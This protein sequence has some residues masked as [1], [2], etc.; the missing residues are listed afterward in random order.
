[1]NA[2]AKSITPC[3]VGLVYVANVVPSL[4]IKASLPF[5]QHR[6]TYFQ[7]L[8][9]ATILMFTS[10][11]VVIIGQLTNSPGLCLFG[12]A[13][14]AAQ[15]GLGEASLLA[16]ASLYGDRSRTA[17][18]AW[19]SGTGFA[20]IF[21]YA[22]V[23]LF[24]R[25]FGAS[26]AVTLFFGLCVPVSYAYVYFWCL[27][28]PS[29]TSSSA[30]S[31]NNRTGEGFQNLVES[32]ELKEIEIELELEMEMTTTTMTTT[33]TTTTTAKQD[34]DKHT[35]PL[36]TLPHSSKET[37][38]AIFNLWPY[39]I[40]LFTVYFAEYAMQSGTWSAMGFPVTDSNARKEFYMNSNFA[41]QIGV[42]ISRSSGNIMQC[43][44]R[45]LWIMPTLQ[46]MFLI[47]FW[48]DAAYMYWYDWSLM[49]PCFV[50]GLLGGATYVGAF[51]LINEEIPKGALR[52]F[53]L[54]A[55]SVADSLGIVMSDLF[56]ILIQMQLYDMHGLSG[57]GECG[58][59]V[60]GTNVTTF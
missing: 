1:M 51:V 26:F 28:M 45:L 13:C 43:S 38:T 4:S 14:G 22:F 3:Y 2:A 44:K 35:I 34:D 36:S 5:W 16:K 41:Y 32:N 20:G 21:G 23:L 37:A 17:L 24:T 58:G 31:S 59:G 8:V 49:I 10:F 42:F 11:I 15:S 54:S 46:V 9:V 40:P 55:A 57:S 19:S 6:V 33:T 48:S 25:G 29:D 50:T 56:G 27:E 52:E 53:S 7:R 39:T 47:F 60:N 12:V 18:S 30:S